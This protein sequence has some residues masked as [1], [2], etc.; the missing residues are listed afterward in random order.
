[1]FLFTGS[2]KPKICFDS[3]S[4]AVNLLK[5]GSC[6]GEI[7]SMFHFSLMPILFRTF[8]DAVSQVGVVGENT[9]KNGISIVTFSTERLDA[10]NNAVKVGNSDTASRRLQCAEI[11]VTG[12]SSGEVCQ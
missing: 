8:L 4:A 3:I 9:A 2:K 5:T 11:D 1:M 6:G 7:P 12:S 10:V